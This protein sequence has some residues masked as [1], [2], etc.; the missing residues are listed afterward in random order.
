[1][2]VRA[3]SLLISRSFYFRGV[4]VATRSIDGPLGG[5]DE[6]LN[7]VYE[8]LFFSPGENSGVSVT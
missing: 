5:R 4:A 1:M 8:H 7:P 2:M 6:S 3:S